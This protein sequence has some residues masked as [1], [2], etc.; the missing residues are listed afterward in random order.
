MK[1]VRL[2]E[3]LFRVDVSIWKWSLMKE[4]AKAFLEIQ[5]YGK[6]ITQASKFGYKYLVCTVDKGQP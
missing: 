2:G 5:G 4:L 6:I 1:I 3:N